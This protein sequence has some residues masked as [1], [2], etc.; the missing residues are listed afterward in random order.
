M[1]ESSL[2]QSLVEREV[3]DQSQK[4]AVPEE[5]V[6]SGA[7]APAFEA[8]RA[9]LGQ[10]V[11]TIQRQFKVKHRHLLRW[12]EKQ[13][14]DLAPLLPAT[15][16]AVMAGGLMLSLLTSAPQVMTGLPT[17]NE[18]QIQ[19][20]LVAA[21]LK[22]DQV[23]AEHLQTVQMELVKQQQ[24]HQQMMAQLQQLVANP[25]I[26]N[27]EAASQQITRTI[28]ELTGVP[29]ATSLEGYELATNV[30]RIG[31]EQ[32]L[33]RYPGDSLASHTLTASGMA[34]GLGAY[35]YFAPSAAALTP[36]AIEREKYYVALQTFKSP[37]WAGNVSA[38]YNWFKYRKMLIYHPVTGRAVV[39]V[40]GDAGPGESTGKAFG[41]SPEVMAALNAHDGRGTPPVVMLF[42]D[43]PHNSIPLGPVTITTLETMALK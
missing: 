15:G 32:H 35:G 26:M 16:R 4:P 21:R 1:A 3:M 2:G 22:S 28:H 30:G 7:E 11:E 17:T 14:Y 25:S 24:Q 5:A 34:P 41:G 9:A 33:K 12:A 8:M 43:D 10:Q 6:R 29:V 39:A 13:G 27:D 37:N 23:R 36:Q 19:Q 40:V 20:H 18:A 31:A 38:T 42:V